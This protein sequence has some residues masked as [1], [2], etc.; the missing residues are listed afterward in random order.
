MQG[1]E[2]RE[3]KVRALFP[4]TEAQAKATLAILV[5][6]LI[7]ALAF[8]VFYGVNLRHAAIE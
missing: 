4:Y 5:G 7:A 6:V 1:P 8:A 2:P 3:V